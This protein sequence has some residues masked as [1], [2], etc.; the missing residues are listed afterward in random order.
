MSEELVALDDSQ[1]QVANI[2]SA[3]R[4]MLR[5]V[6]EQRADLLDE[7][8]RRAEAASLYEKRKHNLDGERAY[9]TLRLLAEAA[10][11]ILAFDEPELLKRQNLTY[12]SAWK[13]LAAAFERDVLLAVIAET[14]ESLTTTRVASRVRDLG[15]SSVPGHTFGLDEDSVPWARARQLAREKQM[16]LTKLPADKAAAT[17]RRRASRDASRQM[18]ERYRAYAREERRRKRHQIKRAASER[19]PKISEAYSLLRRTLLALHEA[20]G[21]VSRAER[22]A[23]LDMAFH[24]LY[25][26]EREIGNALGF[27]FPGEDD[28]RYAIVGSDEE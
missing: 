12:Q 18:T 11:G 23:H 25:E 15:Y 16:D 20:Q 28:P 27:A 9:A 6:E 3:A 14:E 22:K 4:E 17:R 24:H 5:L 8:R 2:A 21:E 7:V 19:G 13:A 10:I 1:A 26:A